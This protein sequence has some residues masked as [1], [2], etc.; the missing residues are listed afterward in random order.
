MFVTAKMVYLTAVTLADDADAATKALLELGMMDF[1]SVKELEGAPQE[2]FGENSA[3]QLRDRLTEL[4]RR[5]DSFLELGGLEQPEPSEFALSAPQNIN[6]EQYARMI[7]YIAASVEDIRTRQRGVQKE[8]EE[9]RNF[10]RL[11]R[12]GEAEDSSVAREL[13]ENGSSQYL[14]VKTGR[15]ALEKVTELR[16]FLETLPVAADI[17]TETD[18]ALVK[19]IVM[20]GDLSRTEEALK[21]FDWQDVSLKEVLFFSGESGYRQIIEKIGK[22][23]EELRGLQED[24]RELIMS[25]RAELEKIWLTLRLG[26]LYNTVQ[27]NFDTT[28][29]TNVFA[30][31]VPAADFNRVVKA[32]KK[33][34]G[35]RVEYTVMKAKEVKSR[36]GRRIE[37]PTYLRHPH[38]MRP[39]QMLVNSYAVPAY[40]TIDS[41]IIVA[42]LFVSMFGFMFA[43][44]GQGA[45]VALA[46]IIVARM[47][48]KKSDAMHDLGVLLIYCGIASVVM[49]VLFGS[50]FGFP[51]LPPLWFDYHG[52]VAEGAPVHR[53]ISP[54]DSI[55]DIMGLALKFGL[56]VI[57]TSFVFSWI[58]CIRRGK[59]IELIL[60]RNGLLGSWMYVVCVW[61]AW[62]YIDSGYKRIEHLDFIM[63]A[64]LIPSLLLFF[65][66]PLLY[67]EALVKG[68]TVRISVKSLFG[69]WVLTWLIELLEFYINAMSNTL[70]FIRV[71]A[72]GIA[73][74][75]L[76][77]AFYG[78]AEGLPLAVKIVIYVLANVLVIALE[79]FSAA[80]N[81]VRLNYYEFFSRFFM[82]DGRLYRPVSLRDRV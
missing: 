6:I 48:V 57:G 7:D 21:D 3:R 44:A 59:W 52:I 56:I 80:I 67:K 66:A 68:E 4:R 77:T 78:I 51:A 19:L 75:A 22:N 17:Y 54:I 62:M 8:L 45:V 23:E 55:M 37:A 60:S 15:V 20:K 61:A 2:A 53:T 73:H 72:L 13:D 65:E 14:Q 33:A 24:A 27:L 26:E 16:A 74:V 64:L 41:T 36:E 38:F 25:K 50:Y 30:G 29:N 79:G 71:A 11:Y 47:Y 10:E 31:W 82:G 69:N 43:D 63:P 46:G 34:T 42:V 76:M 9:W 81:S 32:L 12:S 35:G 28:R 40:N 49:G 1:L 58:N 39:F 5:V 18:T 70:S